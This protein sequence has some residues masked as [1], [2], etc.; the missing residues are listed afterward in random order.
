MQ[1]RI[2]LAALVALLAGAADVRAQDYTVD[3]PASE[4]DALIEEG[5]AAFEAGD[6]DGA[7]ALLDRARALDGGRPE[8]FNNLGVVE[9]ERGEYARAASWF[10]E[11]AYLLRAFPAH[12]DDAALY[13]LQAHDG[14]LEAGGLLLDAGDVVAAR[15]ALAGLVTV[16]PES[17][18][19][20]HNLAV[21]FTDLEWFQDLH[22]AARAMVALE[23]LSDAGWA[24]VMDSFLGW[25]ENTEDD[26]AYDEYLQRYDDTHAQAEALPV[27]LD[28]LRVDGGAGTLTGHVIGGSAPAGENV[29]VRMRFIGRDGVMDEREVTFT[30]PGPGQRVTFSAPGPTAPITGLTYTL[31]E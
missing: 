8:A 12:D 14:M 7:A 2:A 6:L 5:N 18:D 31:V 24:F 20:R 15:D 30:S 3:A 10:L 11:L 27:R 19:A 25:A 1:R 28:Q 13:Y 16:F 22:D 26:A 29:R 17:G 23:P 9:L 21:A 4:Y